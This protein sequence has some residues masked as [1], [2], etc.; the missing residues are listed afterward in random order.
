MA[1]LSS[2]TTCASHTP[3]ATASPA[4]AAGPPATPRPCSAETIAGPDLSSAVP[5]AQVS[6][7]VSTI[8][9][10]SRH[11]APGS[12]G[13][14]LCAASANPAADGSVAGPCPTAAAAWLAAGA[15]LHPHAWLAT[16]PDL[17]RRASSASARSIP[18]GSTRSGPVRMAK[19]AEPLGNSR[20]CPSEALG[21]QRRALA[22]LVESMR[23]E[24]WLPVSIATSPPA[25]LLEG[26]GSRQL[27]PAGAT[28]PARRCQTTARRNSQRWLSSRTG[29]PR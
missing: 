10:T 13:R 25:S 17:V 7:T 23:L 8:A 11:E 28:E 20:G 2:G 18:C 22:P 5:A 9:S 26:A 1:A 27:I 3:P 21:R 19:Q 16:S 14:C 4:M 6:E 29:W 24:R 12:E 15:A